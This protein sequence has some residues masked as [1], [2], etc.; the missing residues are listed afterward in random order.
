[1]KKLLLI[2]LCFPLV[3]SCK[4][5]E[6]KAYEEDA[7]FNVD[8][9]AVV[10]VLLDDIYPKPMAHV[11]NVPKTTKLFF[12]FAAEK[13]ASWCCA[14][15]LL[16]R[17]CRLVIVK[18]LPLS[19]VIFATTLPFRFFTIVENA[20]CMPISREQRHAGEASLCSKLKLHARNMYK[21]EIGRQS[22]SR[23]RHSND[24]SFF[25][26]GWSRFGEVLCMSRLLRFASCW[27]Y[28]EYQRDR[29]GVSWGKT[30][31]N[32][33][34]QCIV[35]AFVRRSSFGEVLCSSRLLRFTSCWV[36]MCSK[37]IEYS[38]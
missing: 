32:D 12:R 17:K 1:M 11:Y 18:F 22:K 38:V 35:A 3:Y 9:R 20:S 23:L 37:R 8:V 13:Y 10:A 27:C 24:H 31:C 15:C 19:L 33:R 5:E 30:S 21:R 29:E 4:F 36:M 2:L 26:L 6:V 28:G 16:W 34:I 14:T 25:R 7:V